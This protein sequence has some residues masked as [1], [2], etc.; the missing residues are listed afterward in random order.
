MNT[1]DGF[2]DFSSQESLYNQNKTLSQKE[3]F[4]VMDQAA[5]FSKLIKK[6]IEHQDTVVRPTPGSHAGQAVLLGSMLKKIEKDG[7][8]T[9]SPFAA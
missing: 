9:S 7:N 2:K 5:F 1:L 3:D 6:A 4:T 8:D